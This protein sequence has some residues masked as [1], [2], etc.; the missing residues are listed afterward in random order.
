MSENFK[1]A[2]VVRKDKKLSSQCFGLASLFRSL[3]MFFK[4]VAYEVHNQKH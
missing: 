2:I 4:T 1:L 3:E